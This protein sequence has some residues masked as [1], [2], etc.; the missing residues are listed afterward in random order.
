MGVNSTN[1]EWFKYF[2]LRSYCTKN[3][4]KNTFDHYFRYVYII[5]F[6]LFKTF[7]TIAIQLNLLNLLLK[8]TM[9]EYK[10]ATPK[11]LFKKLQKIQ[12]ILID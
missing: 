4:S 9:Y 5:L 12:F 3:D 8:K 6:Q 7:D 1:K 11:T 10:L 2:L